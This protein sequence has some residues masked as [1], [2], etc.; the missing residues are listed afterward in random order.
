VTLATCGGGISD[1][2]SVCWNFTNPLGPPGDDANTCN[3]DSGGPLFVD[4]GSGPV[5]AGVTS[6]GSSGNC[7]APDA[8]FD[9]RVSFY[10]GWIESVAGADLAHTSCGASPQ[11]G[12][13]DVIV[14]PFVG[15]VSGATPEGRHQV[16]VPGGA[17]A[18]RVGMN[19]VD[20]GSDFDLYVKFGAPPTTSDYDCRQYGVGQFGFCEFASPLAG[21][22]HGLVARYAGAGNAIGE[23]R[24]A[25]GHCD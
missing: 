14:T 19:A 24:D 9:A 5:V 11:V 7:L 20:D 18:L 3:G 4:S 13:A 21:T 17:S 1:T 6:G 25:H 15:T 8:S 23:V 2:T 10:A 12:D 22:W 16:V